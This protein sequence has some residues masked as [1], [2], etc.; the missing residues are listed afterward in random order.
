M[1]VV[2][3]L[4]AGSLLLVCVLGGD[5]QVV[6]VVCVTVFLYGPILCFHPPTAVSVGFSSRQS[7]SVA[8]RYF[9]ECIRIKGSIDVV[10]SSY[11]MFPDRFLYTTLVFFGPEW[12]CI[13]LAP[14]SNTDISAAHRHLC[15]AQT[16]Q[17]CTDI[18][19][20]CRH[21]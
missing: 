5:V 6:L 11:P 10:L 7:F 15:R 9:L 13:C 21:L 12:K 3:D 19:I 4:S 17:P 14:S 1:V 8:T 18:S 16:S 2:V 20:A